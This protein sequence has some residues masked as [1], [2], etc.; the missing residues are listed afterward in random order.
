MATASNLL[1]RAVSN[2][3]PKNL[4]EE[5]VQSGKPMRLYWGIDPTG[6]KIHL[7]HSVPLRKMK[8]FVDAGHHV[9]FLIGSFTAM[10]GDPSDKESMRQPMT[11]EQV[12]KNFQSYKR[13]AAKIL[14]FS[15]VEVRYNHEWLEKLSLQQLLELASHF[16]IQQMEERDMFKRRMEAGKPVSFHE[17]HYPLMVGYD[18]VVLDVDCEIGGSEQEFNMLAGRTLQKV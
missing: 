2:V 14:D 12:D 6:D 17:F 3:I 9:I 1:T 5:K 15:K 10:I 7:G 4:A 16:T 11:R 13:Q 8:Q 18:S